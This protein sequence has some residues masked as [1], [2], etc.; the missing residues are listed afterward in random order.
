MNLLSFSWW[1]EWLAGWAERL[2]IATRESGWDVEDHP[3][4]DPLDWG[5][6][7]KQVLEELEARD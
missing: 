6:E 5:K 4:P 3:S 1:Q 7:A 2:Q